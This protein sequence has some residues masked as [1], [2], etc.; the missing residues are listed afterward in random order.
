M[1]KTILEFSGIKPVTVTSF[2]SAKG[3]AIAQRAKWL[4][5]AKRLGETVS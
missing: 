4:A 3:S 5:T 1:K 2:G